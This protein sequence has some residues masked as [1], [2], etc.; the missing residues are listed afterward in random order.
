M[1][2]LFWLCIVTI[3]HV[4][5]GYPLLLALGLLG[6]RKL[7]RRG[8][9]QPS[10]SIL[11]PAHNEEANIRQK[12]ENLLALDY[13]PDTFE[14]IVGS[15]GSTDATEQIVRQF[16]NRG[17]RLISSSVQRGKSSIENE[18]VAQ[19]A[20]S[21]LV[22]TDADCTV[23]P[24]CLRII[25]ENFADDTIG[26]VTLQPLYSNATETPITKNESLYLR[27]ESW[28]RSQESDRGLLAAASGW[29]FA[30]R[31]SLWRA[32]HTNHGDDFVL[33]LEVALRGFRN[34]VEPRIVA[35]SRLTQNQLEP[36]LAMKKRIVSKD[37]RGLLANASVLNPFR[38]GPVA[39]SLLSHKLLRWLVPYFLIALFAANLALIGQAPYAMFLGIQL[40]FYVLALTGFVV[41]PSRARALWSVPLSFCLVNVAAL[42]G[43]LHCLTGRTIGHWKPIRYDH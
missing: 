27:Y 38:T 36:M 12:I 28:L 21:I 19:S 24:D 25:V 33:P 41:S 16:A 13:P 37:F 22:F 29:F 3:V 26:L 31:R 20:G 1:L 39:F 10:V 23:P 8:T 35:M 17:V 40:V 6:K 34:I 14:I 18:L 2:I 30:M 4:Y 5:I 43:T 9:V 32:L 15:D 42:V 7:V 11:V